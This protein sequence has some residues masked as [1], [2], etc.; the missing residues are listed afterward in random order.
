MYLFQPNIYIF[1]L[2]LQT[3]LHLSA[4]YGYLDITKLL[5]LNMADVNI[6][7]ADNMTPVHRAALYNK[8]EVIKMLHS[9]VS[10]SQVMK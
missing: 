2:N 9:Y 6:Q 10:N 5:L 7:D 3:P 1:Q 8:V 4:T